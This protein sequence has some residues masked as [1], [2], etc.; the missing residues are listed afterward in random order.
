MFAAKSPLKE[1][2]SLTELTLH[3]QSFAWCSKVCKLSL[4]AGLD[5]ETVMFM[6]AR[7]WSWTPITGAFALDM[8]AITLGFHNGLLHHQHIQIHISGT[9][10]VLIVSNGMELP[11]EILRQSCS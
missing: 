2:N 7:P 10:H 8:H 11:I 1:I 3:D 4:P 5:F 9:R 6:C